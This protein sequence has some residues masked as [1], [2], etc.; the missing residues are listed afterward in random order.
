MQYEWWIIVIGG[1]TGICCSLLGSLLV[2]RKMSMISDAISHTVL[3]GIVFAYIISSQ[4]G[5]WWM[6]ICATTVGLLTS[7]LVEYM[8]QLRVRSDAAIGITFTTLFAVAIL[9]ITIFAE[10]I[11]LDLDHV[12]YGEI[13]F[14]PLETLSIQQIDVGPQALW[15]LSILLLFII[16]YILFSY[17]QLQ[18]MIY[19]EEYA[20][21]IGMPTKTIH[22]LMM[23][24]VSLTIVAAFDIVGS[25]LVISMI[26]VPAATALLIAKSFAQML[27]MSMFFAVLA[28][29][30]GFIFAWTFDVSI[31]G[32]MSVF[33]GVIF[34]FIFAFQKW[35]ALR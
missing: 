1:L 11:H 29:T 35:F 20:K 21:A 19:D 5:G 27:W 2:L 26:V 18:T 6:F 8:R 16:L 33:T 23:T 4:F 15:I 30:I 14:A 22:Y 12:L 13:A 25:I 9:L 32:A 34:T 7:F 10:N 31:S 3:L 17:R 24:L 28:S